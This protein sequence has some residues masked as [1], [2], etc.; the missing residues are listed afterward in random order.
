VTTAADGRFRLT[1]VGRDRLV[2]LALE[3]PAIA[4][5][6]LVV[7]TRPAAAISSSGGILGATFDCVALPSRTI[8]GLVRDKAT[9]KPVPGVKVS[10]ETIGPT[11]FTDQDG[12][13]ELLGYPGPPCVVMAQPQRGQPYFAAAVR[14]PEKL[15]TDPLTPLLPVRLR[16]AAA[17]RLPEKLATDPLT[18]DFNLVSGIPLRGRVT[19]QTTGKPPKRAVVEYYPLF[20]NPHSAALTNC[21]KLM[22]ASS[23]LVQPDGSYRL[24]VLPG[25][26]VVLVAASPRDSYAVARLDDRELANLFGDGKPHGGGSWI[27]IAVEGREWDRCVD[28]YNALSL[29]KPDERAGPLT[30]DLTVQRAR[31][32][33]GTVVGPD[34]KPLSGVRV[35]GLTS[36]PDA[37]TLER[38]SF[39]VEGLNPRRTR[40][41]SF[42]HREKGLGKVMT[43]RGDATK[44]LMVQLEP[45]GWN[46]GRLVDRHNKPVP[47]EMVICT[48][49]GIHGLEVPAARTDGEG[50]FRVCLMAEQ[51]YG[52]G[53]SSFRHLLGDEVTVTVESGGSKDLGDLPLSD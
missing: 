51:K 29:I 26:G 44:P 32:L 5:T 7:T 33:R 8:R 19:N 42:H 20:P 6:D 14:L 34:G 38:A 39:T 45:C 41:L 36:M 49:P 1:G 22:P 16:S 13:Y 50:R 31:G 43:L 30:L 35:S 10:I 15:A 53:L 25:P 3:G 23:A 17:V 21:T 46:S 27:H 9:G 52:L 37:E 12:R 11:T 18:A 28:R 48:P 40:Q 47:G 4:H 24:M 2:S